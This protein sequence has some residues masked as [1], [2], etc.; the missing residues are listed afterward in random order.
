[1]RRAILARLV[2]KAR[3]ARRE[4]PVR[5]ASKAQSDP[6]DRRAMPVIPV[7]PVPMVPLGLRDLRGR[8]VNRGLLDWRGLPAP[9]VMPDPKAPRATPE[10]LGHRAR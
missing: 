7:Q 8:P 10:I 4:N 5:K 1:M 9:L 6:R 2:Q 3:L